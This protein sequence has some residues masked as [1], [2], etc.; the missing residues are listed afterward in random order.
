MRCKIVQDSIYRLSG[1]SLSHP[2][3]SFFNWFA[4]GQLTLKASLL[5]SLLFPLSFSNY[6]YWFPPLKR[7]NA[8]PLRNKFLSVYVLL[9]ATVKALNGLKTWQL[10][11]VEPLR[12]IRFS[13]GLIFYAYKHYHSNMSGKNRLG[14][15]EKVPTK[16]YV[17]PPNQ[18]SITC[19]NNAR[20][21]YTSIKATVHPTIPFKLWFFLL[22]FKLFYR[23]YNL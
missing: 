15:E 23:L 14:R 3:F 16:Q 19:L 18:T 8:C 4:S 12:K 10:G 21:L 22:F 2:S 1:V 6:I 20:F 11:H 9:V 5:A 17:Q 7:R 13:V